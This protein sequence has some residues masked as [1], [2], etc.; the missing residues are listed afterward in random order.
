MAINSSAAQSCTSPDGETQAKFELIDGRP[1][2]SV[3]KNGQSIIQKSKMGFDL[4]EQNDLI[5]NFSVS[6]IQLDEKNETW[7]QPWGEDRFIKNHY[8]ES[9]ITLTQKDELKRQLIIRFRAFNDGVAF[10][11]EFPVQENLRD[12]IIMDELTQFSLPANGST[13]H[14]DALN[15]N[16]YEYLYERKNIDE[17]ENSEFASHTPL[18]VQQ[19]NHYISIHEAN[20]SDY[21]S[22]ILRNSGDQTLECDLVPWSDGDAVKVSKTRVTPWRTI[23][24]GSKA[25]DLINSHLSLNLNEPSKIEDTSWIKPSKYIGIWW[26]M[27]L[28]N[29]SWGSGKKHGAT[30]ENT[31]KYI[32]FAAQNGFKGI[33]VEGWNEGWDPWPKDGHLFRFTEAYPDFDINYLTKYATSKGVQLVGHHETAGAIKNYEDQI[34]DAFALYN[35]LGINT[36]KT[37][38]VKWGQNLNRY[39]D[40]GNL[41]G[42]EWHHGQWMVNHFRKVV[43]IAAK[44]KVMLVVHE[45]IK[46]TGI[47][48]TWPN[49][50]TRECARGQ[51]FNAW[52]AEGGNPPNHSTILPFTR[53]LSGP[54]DFT[55]GIFDIKFKKAGKL[56]KKG[57]VNRV[58]TTLAKQLA[59]YIC[60]Y[61]PHHMAADLPKNYVGNPALKF[62]KDVP[63][64]WEISRAIHG[65]IGEYVVNVRKDRNSSEWYLGALTNE[66]ERIIRVNL[67]FLEKSVKYKAEIYADSATTD[68]ENNPTAISIS[69]KTVKSSDTLTLY[70]KAGGGQAIRFVPQQ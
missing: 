9:V 14:L 37:G 29:Y 17:L 23:N 8:N 43:E 35:K 26:G 68:L 31:K 20:L 4:K 42:K 44:N 52:D 63:T 54:M 11:Y 16:R 3:S 36:V 18:T 38:Y 62:I 41:L 58:N 22:M 33:L 46:D 7:E 53:M 39:D 10:R 51:E 30:T 67:R 15:K 6:D 2:Y 56:R 13:W 34:K 19:V 70:L 5:E 40:S 48:R 50:T 49:M 21:S 27:H 66:D 25:I 55:P 59:L 12:F 64:D 24:I 32:D 1:V 69:E 65:E 57:V 28:G 61:S 45:G 47:R 60:I